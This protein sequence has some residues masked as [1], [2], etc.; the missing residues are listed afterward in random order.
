M[1]KVGVTGGMPAAGIAQLFRNRGSKNAKL[2]RSASGG[3][4]DR[5]SPPQVKAKPSKSPVPGSPE[6]S[7]V[8]NSTSSP[9]LR[10]SF[11]MF[12]RKKKHSNKDGDD[13][14]RGSCEDLY[15]ETSS[16]SSMS[17]VSIREEELFQDEA[18][19][20]L[21]VASTPDHT[22]QPPV[23]EPEPVTSPVHD[24]LN[25]SRNSALF[26][27]VPSLFD[28][29]TKTS[30]FD[31]SELDSLFAKTE[32]SS[33]QTQTK[34]EAKKETEETKKE[35]APAK[36][37]KQEKPGTPKLSDK[38]L[39]VGS[40]IAPNKPTRKS[41]TSLLDL[42]A[43]DRA[44]SAAIQATKEREQERKEKAAAKETPKRETFGLFE[45]DEKAEEEDSLF[46]TKKESAKK[47]VPK[48][49]S[50]AEE[51][52]KKDSPKV[53]HKE[54]PKES[55]MDSPKKSPKESPKESLKESPKK[56]PKEL[57]RKEFVPAS[58]SSKDD[59]SADKDD[60]KKISTILSDTPS[61]VATPS[62]VLGRQ[63]PKPHRPADEKLFDDSLEKKAE[64]KE[65]KKEVKKEEKK[66]EVKKEEKKQETRSKE[67]RKETRSKE[68][69][70]ETRSKERRKETREERCIFKTF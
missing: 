33:E 56:S 51:L 3:S 67:R 59:I 35:D 8:K 18:V 32:L 52:F 43:Y 54:S 40:R 55:L 6:L 38:R 39:S 15:S 62:P 1:A 64:K 45:E 69:R 9:S 70:K 22:Y 5:E 10:G 21:V 28:K 19:S 58:S 48:K 57:P 24:S 53:S 31:T 30:L 16:L 46:S 41:R 37:E 27:E 42:K 17:R 20:P 66:Q 12:K 61:K 63:G 34:E 65:D 11:K 50:L 47:E 2:A 14:S 49:D 44:A 7:K 60:S 25:S 13:I 29:D 4:K 26:K 68:R 36:E 23:P